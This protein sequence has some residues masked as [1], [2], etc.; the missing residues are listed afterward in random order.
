MRH[1]AFVKIWPAS[2]VIFVGIPLD[3]FADAFFPGRLDLPAQVEQL[4]GIDAV[5]VVIDF[6]VLHKGNPGIRILRIA[7]AAG[8]DAVSYN[9]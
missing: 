2:E 7:H 3:S 1:E 9:L 5:V 4:G 8:S 6:S